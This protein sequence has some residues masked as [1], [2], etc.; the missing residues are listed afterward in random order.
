MYTNLIEII[1]TK[2]CTLT[3]LFPKNLTNNNRTFLL[4]ITYSIII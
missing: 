4:Y 1:I 2:K 3:T